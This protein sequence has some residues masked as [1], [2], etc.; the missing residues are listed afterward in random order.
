MLRIS[1]KVVIP[2]HE[3]EWHAIR[4][5]GSGGQNVNKVATAVQLFFKVPQSSLPDFYKDRLLRKKDHRITEAGTIIIKAQEHRSQEKNRLEALKRLQQLIIEA[6]KVEKKRKASAPT[7]AAR[8][9]RTDSKIHRGRI[10][11]LRRSPAE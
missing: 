4:S 1:S 6:G 9:R 10:K 5:Q 7:K 11:A 2:M 3:I 8:K